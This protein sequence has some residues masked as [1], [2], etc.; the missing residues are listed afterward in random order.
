MMPYEFDLLHRLRGG[1]L[2]AAEI[3]SALSRSQR[4]LPSSGE[5]VA[6]HLQRLIAAGFVDHTETGTPL[7]YALTERG[8]EYVHA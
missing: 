5:Q 4:R 2:S 8:R 6:Q 1:A 3:A 7:F